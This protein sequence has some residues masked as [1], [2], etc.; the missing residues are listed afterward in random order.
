MIV[1]PQ[2]STQPLVKQGAGMENATLSG[3]RAGPP[4]PGAIN[5]GQ[6]FLSEYPPCL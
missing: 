4:H 2:C 1:D 5:R 6:V 3:E